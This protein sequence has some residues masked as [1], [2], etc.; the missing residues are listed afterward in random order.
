MYAHDM[1][2]D[3]VAAPRP[4]ILSDEFFLSPAEHA[5]LLAWC[6]TQVPWR[7]VTLVFGGRGIPVPRRLAWYG[8]VD[9]A[10]SGIRHAA[11]P[12]PEQ[13]RS[14]AARIEAWL[15]Q[16]GHPASFNSLLLNYY[17]DGNDSIGMHADDETQLGPQPT[18]ASVSLGATRTFVFRHKATSLK[19]NEPLHGGSLLVMK[20]RTQDDWLHGI[21]KEP[22]AGERINLTFRNS[23]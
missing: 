19:L 9:Y 10:Y 16:R 7:D 11:R 6:K 14:V 18:I 13:L 15:A 12:M 20:G 4:D 23:F 21:P 3:E 22:A 2:P 17:R 8:P 5:E 1:F